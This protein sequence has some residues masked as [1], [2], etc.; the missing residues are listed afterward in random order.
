VIAVDGIRVLD[1]G[2]VYRRVEHR[3]AGTPIAYTLRRGTFVETLTLASR[4][5]SRLDYWAIF[6]SY[7]ATGL[8]Y[9]ALGLLASWILGDTPQGRGLLYVGG[10][11]GIYALSGAT[12]YQPG[13]DMRLH[14]LAEAFLPA[15]LVNLTCVFP[16]ERRD[17]AMPAVATAW[18]IS[19]ALAVPYQLLLHQPAAYSI[20]HATCETY[21]GVAGLGFGAALIIE[22]ARAPHAPTPLL[23]SAVAGAI[24]GLGVPAVVMTI[25]GLTG[26]GLPVNVCTATAFLFPLCLGYGLVR[27]RLARR[28]SLAAIAT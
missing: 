10:V 7:M 24:L 13:G 21:M 8:L 1:S 6:G 25:S 19:L 12:F 16:R 9:L 27:D 17:I 23:R 3:P 5:F 11:A 14:A 26:G 18:W 15:A 4:T 2:D 28:M 22:R 20:L